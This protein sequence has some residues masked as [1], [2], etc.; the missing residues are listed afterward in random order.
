MLTS[1]PNL[2]N[3]E[4]VY[5]SL[6]APHHLGCGSQETNVASTKSTTI[7]ISHQK[8]GLPHTRRGLLSGIRFQ[9]DR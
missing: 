3:S 1:I 2:S 9:V 4:T 8:I 5:L 7:T 6:K